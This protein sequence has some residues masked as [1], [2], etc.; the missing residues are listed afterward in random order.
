M[1][2]CRTAVLGMTLAL[3]AAAA[4]AAPRFVAGPYK[5]TAMYRQAT[6]VITIAPAGVPIPAV[7]FGKRAFGPGTMSWAFATGECGE[8]RW[9]EES[10][11]EIADANVAAF[12][13]AGVPYIVSTGGQGGMFTC[14]SDAGMERFIK[15][16]Q[17]ARLVGVDFDIE[18]AQSE[19]QIESLVA[20]AVHAQKI[21][22][23]LRFSFTVATHAA[24][25]GSKKSLNAKG[26]TILAAARKSGLRDYTFN[27]MVMDYGP[28]KP[29]NCVVRAG[30]CEMGLSALQAVRNVHQKHGIPMN[31]IELTAMIGVNDVAANDFTVRDARVLAKA[32]KLL[33]LA[34][35]HFWSIDRD[36]PCPEPSTGAVATCS[37]IDAGVGEFSRIM[38]SISK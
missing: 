20:R 10:G 32:V 29:E 5:H 34:G 9:G 2:L 3:S 4:Q 37:G 27:L 31:Q 21:W 25:D 24:S 17:S 16:Y 14:A 6:H 36:R 8:E 35:L 30:V 19:A 33:N 13:K 28:P 38:S 22:P 15:R 1:S 7:A 18:D 26:E 11:Q 12:V 23:A